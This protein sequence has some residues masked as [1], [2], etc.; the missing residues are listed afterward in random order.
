[1]NVLICPL[2][3]FSGSLLMNVAVFS[4]VCQPWEISSAASGFVF[5]FYCPCSSR[6]GLLNFIGF[7][8]SQSRLGKVVSG[9]RQQ[10]LESMTWEF[11]SGCKTL[12]K[13][14][15]FLRTEISHG[16]LPIRLPWWHFSLVAFLGE[17]HRN[18]SAALGLVCAAQWYMTIALAAGRQHFSPLSSHSLQSELL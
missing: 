11:K 3:H 6:N 16:S 5:S 4:W 9:A 7:S 1:M 18:A 2:I 14:L 8:F 13:L 17:R 12:G 15:L 10:D